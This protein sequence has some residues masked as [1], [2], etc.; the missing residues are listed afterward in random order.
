M[1][2]ENLVHYQDEDLQLLLLSTEEEC[3]GQKYETV[4]ICE[5]DVH[6]TLERHRREVRVAQEALDNA[7]RAWGEVLI[8]RGDI[9]NE[10]KIRD[11][12]KERSNAL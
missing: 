12:I 10:L 5:D 4:L 11:A 3:R 2:R 9:Q 1:N 7:R 6:R 8:L